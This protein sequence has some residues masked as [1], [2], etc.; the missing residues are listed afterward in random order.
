MAINVAQDDN[1]QSIEVEREEVQSSP[2]IEK[3]SVTQEKPKAP[4]MPHVEVD[5]YRVRVTEGIRFMWGE[6]IL[7]YRRGDIIKVS[8]QLFDILWARGCI[9]LE[10]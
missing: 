2:E 9:T 7:Q 10:P 8:K 1:Y 3:P 6:E 5:G 4:E